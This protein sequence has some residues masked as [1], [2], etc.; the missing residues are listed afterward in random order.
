MYVLNELNLDIIGICESF[1]KNNETLSLNGYSWYGNN[2]NNLHKNARRGSGGVG[3]FVKNSILEQYS[4]TIDISM[5]DVILLK[6]EHRVSGHKLTLC[7]CCLPPERSSRRCDGEAF[8]NDL[9]LKFHELYQNEGVVIICGDFNSRCGDESDFI[10]GAD[11]IPPR[12]V[13]DDKMNPYGQLFLDFLIDCNL[14]MINGRVGKNDFTNINGNGSSV[15]DYIVV[16]YEQL[17]KYKHFKVHTMTSLIN[18]FKHA[19]SF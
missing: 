3:A 2:R 5:E 19:R 18:R 9:M 6:F 1:L 11:S 8:F 16:P 10:E 4:C 13:I 12:E 15:V 17:D 7:I 14:C